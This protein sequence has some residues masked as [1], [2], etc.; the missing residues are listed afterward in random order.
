MEKSA[1]APKSGHTKNGEFMRDFGS[2]QTTKIPASQLRVCNK[3]RAASKYSVYVWQTGKT[4]LGEAFN[5]FQKP[6]DRHGILPRQTTTNNWD[7]HDTITGRFNRTLATGKLPPTLGT[8][9]IEH[10]LP[11]QRID[12]I[13]PPHSDA[14]TT[15]LSSFQ[16]LF[17]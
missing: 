14:R 9:D 6:T 12:V 11:V 16:S 8:S 7:H 5:N 1:F 3:P 10:L 4:V 15:N 2:R 17:L 13:L